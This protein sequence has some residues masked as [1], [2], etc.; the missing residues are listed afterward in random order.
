VDHQWPMPLSSGGCW[1]P[2][3]YSDVASAPPVNPEPVIPPL[4]VNLA[5]L[6]LPP[7]DDYERTASSPPSHLSCSDEAH[8]L[9]SGTRPT[10]PR[11]DQNAPSVDEIK[12]HRVLR[13]PDG[14]CRCMS[15]VTANGK[16]SHYT[17]KSQRPPK[18]GQPCGQTFRGQDEIVRH[19]KTSQWH[20]ELS[21]EHRPIACEVCGKHLSRR[22]ALTRHMR[23]THLSTLFILH[24]LVNRI[25]TSLSTSR[26]KWAAQVY[27][28]P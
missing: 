9:S 11:P 19:L 27:S 20:K 2:C 24:R 15:I 1:Y 10:T 7:G 12:G 3:W 18:V 8:N 4:T 16:V 25:L 17:R 28:G 14:S 5:Q 21:D 6:V 23:T 22:D 26:A 13:Y